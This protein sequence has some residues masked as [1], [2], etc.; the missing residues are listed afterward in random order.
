V[1]LVRSRILNRRRVVLAM[2]AV[3]LLA[4]CS[5]TRGSGQISSESRQV[6]GFSKVE[7]SGSGEL[8]IEQ[9]DMSGSGVA[10]VHGRDALDLQMSG[11]GTLTY[12]GDP[13]QVTQQIS[14][15]GK[16]IKK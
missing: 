10:S 13:K 15:S 12:A 6:S 1:G 11:S 4:A 3:M 16:V 9:K 2:L 8:T 5:V 7:L 14:G